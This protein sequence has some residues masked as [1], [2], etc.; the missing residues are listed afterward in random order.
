MGWLT[1][2]GYCQYV[3]NRKKISYVSKKFEILANIN[4]ETAKKEVPIE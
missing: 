2:L 1:I 3:S 4:I